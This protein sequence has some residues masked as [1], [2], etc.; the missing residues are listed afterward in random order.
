M[1]YVEV[2]VADEAMLPKGCPPQFELTS[3]A[4]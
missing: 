4:R 3:E 1:S 2:A